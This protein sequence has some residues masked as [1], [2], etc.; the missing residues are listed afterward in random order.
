MPRES[1]SQQWQFASGGA[2]YVRKSHKAFAHYDPTS[3]RGKLGQNK[4]KKS[5]R[6][7]AVKSR[8][9]R[10]RQPCVLKIIRSQLLIARRRRFVN[11]SREALICN[12][13]PPATLQEGD[14][15][16]FVPPTRRRCATAPRGEIL[17]ICGGGAFVAVDRST[18]QRQRRSLS[19]IDVV[20]VSDI[21]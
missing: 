2:K 15:V 4:R 10:S 7:H 8:M 21:W 14:I 5:L 17:R 9:T 12:R 6:S 13:H 11:P 18:V 3:A 16:N 19:L 20:P 1:G